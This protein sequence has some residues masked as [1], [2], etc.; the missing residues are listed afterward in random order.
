M[1]V[2]LI[3]QSKSF[4]IFVDHF[5]HLLMEF[6][7]SHQSMLHT[8][9]K[10]FSFLS[11]NFINRCKSFQ[12]FIVGY[13]WSTREQFYVLSLV[14][15]IRQSESFGILVSQFKSP[16]IEQFLNFYWSVLLTKK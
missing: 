13:N 16:V 4:C 2:N 7:N 6:L 15:F 11:F 5:N 9:K 8:N 14:D 12:I 10:T 3:G 1:L